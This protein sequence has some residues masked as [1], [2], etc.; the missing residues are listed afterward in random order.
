MSEHFMEKEK[1]RKALTYDADRP[2]PV[3]DAEYA[4][5]RTAALDK[6]AWIK[7]RNAGKRYGGDYLDRLIFEEVNA[8]RLQSY[9][10]AKS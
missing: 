8:M 9:L 7:S 10:S 4:Q 6:L 1:A 2:D 3:T 5:A